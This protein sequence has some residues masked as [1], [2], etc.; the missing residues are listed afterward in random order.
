MPKN[1]ALRSNAS[2]SILAILVVAG[3]LGNYFKFPFT[4]NIDFLFGSI[5]V[6]IAVRLYGLGWGTLAAA[7]ASFHTIIIWQHPYAFII[8]TCEACFVGWRLRRTKQSLL[9]LDMLYWLL[10]GMPLAWIFYKYFLQLNLTTTAIIMVKQGV[11]GMLNALLAQLLLSNVPLAKWAQRPSAISTLSFKQTIL[12]LLVACIFLPSMM[13]MGLDNRNTM[14]QQEALVD[15]TL[16]ASAADLA[17]ELRLWQQQG[18]V[19]L[20]RQLIRQILDTSRYPLAIESTLLDERDRTVVTTRSDLKLQQPFDRR[21]GADIRTLP[22]A[23]YHWLPTLPGKPSAIRWSQSVYVK[24][25]PIGAGTPWTLAMEAPIA[26]QILQLQHHY[27]KSMILLLLIAVISILLANVLSRRLVQPI[28]QLAQLTTNLPEKLLKREPISLPNSSVLEIAALSNNFQ[29]MAATLKQQFQEIHDTNIQLQRTKEKAEIANQAKSTFIANMSH[30]LRS[31]LNAILGF[32]QII[33]RSQT[34]PPEHQEN[35][36][37]ISRSGEHLLSLINNVLDLSKIEAGKTTLNR[38]S[39]DL[40]RLLDDIHDLFQLKA[41]EKNLQFQVEYDASVPRYICT[42]EVKL[43]QISINLVN[44]AIKFTEQGGILLQVEVRENDALPT[45]DNNLRTI[46]FAVKDTGAGIAPQELETL[47]EAFTQTETGQKAQEGTGLGL[48]ISRQFVQLMGG[49]LTVNSELGKGTTFK[50]DIRVAEVSP[51]HIERQS[52]QRRVI[53]LEPN[54]PCYR[55]LIADDKPINRQLLIKLLSPLGFAVKE[56]SNGKEAIEIWQQWKPNLIWMD[57]RMPVMDGYA[58][59]QT[60]KATT[61]GQATAVIA[62]TASMFEEERAVVLS[63]G[64]DDFLRKP[65]REN[66]IFT[67]MEKHL[68]VK[69]LY[70]DLTAQ[71][72]NA[73]IEGDESLARKMELLPDELRHQLQTAIVTSDLAAIAQVTDRI[74]AEDLSLATTIEQCLKNFEYEKILNL[75][76]APQN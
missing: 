34:L 60:I 50:F 9:F 19:S 22:S 27:L 18:Q 68:G 49:D 32:A 13:L 69:Y 65:F 66:D 26:P 24:E 45:A 67:A 23:V 7:I 21:T 29:N 48:P 8:F 70:E 73:P 11:N 46:A 30:E 59:T 47:F 33:T 39:F 12:N 1:T 3:Y 41:E 14:R 58:A 55:I 64:C 72:A 31:P 10:I 6:L 28:L 36:S 16:Q 74:K 75:I 71:Q 35:V 63:A 44:N 54:Q 53:A 38:A 62:L 20:E 52:P 25:L 51:Q 57:M 5:A 17:A 42:D 56:A 76:S 2:F 61:Q 40:H 4:F 37:I 15:V 43:R